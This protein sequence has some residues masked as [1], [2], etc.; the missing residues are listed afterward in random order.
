MAP[1]TNIAW[2]CLYILPQDISGG[3]KAHV[4]GFI[5]DHTFLEVAVPIYTPITEPYKDL[6]SKPSVSIE[7]LMTEESLHEHGPLLAYYRAH[8]DFVENARHG[9]ARHGTSLAT[10][11]RERYPSMIPWIEYILLLDTLSGI[12]TGL[13]SEA[14]QVQW[15]FSQAIIFISLSLAPSDDQ[16]CS[17]IA[18]MTPIDII[19]RLY[20]GLEDQ[21][22][23][24]QPDPNF[25]VMIRMLLC[26]VGV[27]N[28][29][30]TMGLLSRRELHFARAV[31]T[32][33]GGSDSEKLEHVIDY[34]AFVQRLSRTQ[35]FRGCPLDDAFIGQYAQ[36]YG[37]GLWSSIPVS[38]VLYA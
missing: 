37:I 23:K 34:P 2:K 11:Y 25:I 27:T 5:P 4:V 28:N 35:M 31:Y 15:R 36:K 26:S 12:K 10:Y 33:L 22:N 30:S 21:Y 8:F 19:S 24:P 6:S 29:E 3:Y 14:A 7:S 1:R 32:L 38:Q 20:Q 16:L 17:S 18:D 9:I 13:T